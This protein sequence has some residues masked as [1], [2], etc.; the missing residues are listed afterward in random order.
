VERYRDY[1]AIV[2]QE[3]AK[4][5]KPQPRKSFWSGARLI[6]GLED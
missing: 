6:S 5:A 3:K 1:D 4:A 2:A